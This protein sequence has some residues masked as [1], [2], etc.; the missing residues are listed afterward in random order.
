[1]TERRI[2]SNGLG[3]HHAWMVDPEKILINFTIQRLNRGIMAYGKH[4]P[5]Q[6]L[7]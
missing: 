4:R 1:M 7:L 6:H 2:T 5:Q 3:T